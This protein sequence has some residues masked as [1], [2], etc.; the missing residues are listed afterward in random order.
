MTVI[1]PSNQISTGLARSCEQDSF[2]TR[3]FTSGFKGHFLTFLQ[4]VGSFYLAPHPLNSPVL[5]PCGTVLVACGDLFYPL[6]PS[7]V[8]QC[9]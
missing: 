6:Q 7:A 5:V 9:P 2:A 4:V 3:S 1:S 8:L